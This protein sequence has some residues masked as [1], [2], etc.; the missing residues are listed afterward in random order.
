MTRVAD[1]GSQGRPDDWVVARSSEDAAAANID[2]R[3]G[4]CSLAERTDAELMQD[5]GARRDDAFAEVYRRHGRRVLAAARRLLADDASAEDLTQDLFLR[6]WEDPTKY[7]HTRGPLVAY[8][9]TMARG[10]AVDMRRADGARSRRQHAHALLDHREE[11]V[12]RAV[13]ESLLANDLAQ[14]LQALSAGESRAIR[15][16]YF[17]GYTYRQVAVLLGRPEGTVKSQVRSGLRKLHP[18]ALVIADRSTHGAKVG[19]L[20]RNRGG[21]VLA[22]GPSHSSVS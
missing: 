22:D 13:L 19:W 10:R 20:P 4:P 21:S 17:G 5:I 8:L 15:L 9:L 1:A 12:E 6:L 11:S 7:D 2:D 3:R 18:W 16:A 14:S